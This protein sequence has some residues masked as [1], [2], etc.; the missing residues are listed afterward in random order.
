MYTLC[1]QHAVVLGVGHQT[2][3]SDFPLFP[4]LDNHSDNAVD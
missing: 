2:V 3:P 4:P 1:H